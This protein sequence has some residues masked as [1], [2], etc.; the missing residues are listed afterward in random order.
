MINIQILPKILSILHEPLV[1]LLVPY[2]DSSDDDDVFVSYLKV[3]L[4]FIYHV[5]LASC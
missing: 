3:G 5:D 4:F 2:S 1:N